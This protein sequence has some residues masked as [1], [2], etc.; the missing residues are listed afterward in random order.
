MHSIGAQICVCMLQDSRDKSLNKLKFCRN[1]QEDL[2]NKRRTKEA[3]LLRNLRIFGKKT[4]KRCREKVSS[5]NSLET[6]WSQN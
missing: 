2:N 1:D 4:A 5:G 3:S 6:F